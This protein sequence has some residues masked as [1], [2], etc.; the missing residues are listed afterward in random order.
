[1]TDGHEVYERL[2]RIEEQIEAHAA[3]DDA[4]FRKME[5]ISTQLDE[6]QSEFSRYRGAVGGILLLVT[7]VTTFIKMFGDSIKEFLS[8]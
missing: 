2:A 1:M 3:Y 7:A 6:I 8:S 4:R 5:K